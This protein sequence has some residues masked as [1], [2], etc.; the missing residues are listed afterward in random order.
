MLLCVN[1]CSNVFAVAAVDHG[2]GMDTLVFSKS[3]IYHTGGLLQNDLQNFHIPMLVKYRS[4]F[5]A[6]IIFFMLQLLYEILQAS[7]RPQNFT[8]SK[9]FDNFSTL[10]AVVGMAVPLVFLQECDLDTP[11]IGCLAATFQIAIHYHV[12]RRHPLG[13]QG[14]F[15]IFIKISK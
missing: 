13:H 11:A 3:D 7:M 10:N 9:I 5:S 12:F 15:F 1:L 6:L 14:S 4:Q 8:R 2:N